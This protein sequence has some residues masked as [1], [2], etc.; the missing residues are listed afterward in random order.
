MTWPDAYNTQN[1]LGE[2]FRK[3][4]PGASMKAM[5]RIVKTIKHWRIH[6]TDDLRNVSGKYNAM[7]RG[8][9]R[10]T[11]NSGTVISVIECGAGSNRAC[12]WIKSR[13]ISIS[14]SE[15][16]RLVRRENPELFAHWYLLRASNVCSRAV[17]RETV[18][19]RSV[20][21]LGVK[22]PSAYSTQRRTQRRDGSA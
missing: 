8:V 14:Q 20:S 11:V 15:H 3:C 19:Y 21:S 5:V 6:R 10:I 2:L 1:F 18:T 9:D 12:K 16:R 7:I 13:R 4:M 17:L 22:H